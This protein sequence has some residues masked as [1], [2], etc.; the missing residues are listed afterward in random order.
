MMPTMTADHAHSKNQTMFAGLALLLLAFDPI[1]Y[2]AGAIARRSGAVVIDLE[3]LRGKAGFDRTH[4][5]MLRALRDWMDLCEI[6]HRVT[7]VVDHGSEASTV[8]TPELTITFAGPTRKA[9]DVIASDLSFF[10]RT[11][12]TV[13]VTADRGLIDRCERTTIQQS[14]EIMSPALLLQDLDR[15][16]RDRE[17]ELEE[18]TIVESNVTETTYL[19]VEKVYH[20]KLAAE[21]L[22]A[23][24]LLKNR[25]GVKNKRRKKLKQK[26]DKLR[27]KLAASPLLDRVSHILEHGSSTENLDDLAREEQ[28]ILLRR[29]E[30]ARQ[31][32]HRKER[33]SDRV[34]L[35]EHWRV[36]LTDEF[37]KPSFEEEMIQGSAVAYAFH[38]ADQSQDLAH[39]TDSLRVVVLSDTHG[40]ESKLP[41]L[42]TGDLLL[43]LGDFAVDRTSKNEMNRRLDLFDEWLAQHPHRYKIVLRG[44]HDPKSWQP[45]RSEATYIT[46]P[47]E[48]SIGGF[49]LSLVPYVPGRMNSRSLPRKYDVVASHVP[50]RGILDRCASGKNAGS[51]SL[52][53]CVQRNKASTPVLW[54]CGHIHEARGTVEARLGQDK[55]TVV[56]N[57]AMANSGIARTIEHG[58][59]VLDLIQD[60]SRGN[61]KSVQ[62]I[63]MPGQYTHLNERSGAFFSKHLDAVECRSLL[64]AVDLGLRTGLSLFD[65]EGRLLRFEY[66]HFG[67]PDELRSNAERILRE[68]E[69]AVSHSSGSPCLISRVAVEGN[70]ASLWPVWRDACEGRALLEVKPDQWREDLL[71]F[72]DRRSG[73][74]A[75][76]A[77]RELAQSIL[78]EC[79]ESPPDVEVLETVSLP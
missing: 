32:N 36:E 19:S 55:D 35:A 31:A 37:G 59:V 41:E 40:F 8:C 60:P 2:K 57:A 7:I 74:S 25:I 50:P 46:K 66:F 62:L 45:Y 63:A 65:D 70:D 43:H 73:E 77:S 1:A 75:K 27:E 52:L 53:R 68:W 69:A 39:S 21:L 79:S 15:L 5:E 58:P 44:N 17:T 61:K 51:Q 10:G 72:D 23:E 30:R 48:I 78:K 24:V 13:V 34:V 56:V 29:L 67:S 49:S 6:K 16:A 33:T 20:I 11:Y 28:Q 14:L 71:T 12:D 76:A 3:N 18:Q 38:L 54:L 64:L 26:S 42:P 47:S 22:E 9:D 4:A